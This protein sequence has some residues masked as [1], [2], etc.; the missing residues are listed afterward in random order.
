M[1]YTTDFCLCYIYI[2]M[3]PVDFLCF[4]LSLIDT[5]ESDV[6]SLKPSFNLEFAFIMKLEV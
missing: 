6:F 4:P 5:D 1:A 2:S 3:L